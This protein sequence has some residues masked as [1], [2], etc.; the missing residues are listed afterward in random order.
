[1]ALFLLEMSGSAPGVK[2]QIR[3]SLLCALAYP[4]RTLIHKLYE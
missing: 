1:M 2:V 3:R 4:L